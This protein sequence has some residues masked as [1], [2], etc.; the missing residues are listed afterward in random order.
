[1]KKIIKLIALPIFFL[2]FG[3]L[4]KKKIISGLLKCFIFPSRSVKYCL[5]SLPSAIHIVDVVIVVVVIVVI[6]VV[7]VIIVVVDVVDYS[8]HDGGKRLDE[9][10]KRKDGERAAT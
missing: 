8:N 10:Q 3:L 9:G 1:L 5:S 4:F 6:V 7:V 2:N